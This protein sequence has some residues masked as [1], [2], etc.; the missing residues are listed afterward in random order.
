MQSTRILGL[1]GAAVVILAVINQLHRTYN[2]WSTNESV[3]I[4][5]VYQI[6]GLIGCVGVTAIIRFG[7]IVVHPQRYLWTVMSWWLLAVAVGFYV[8]ENHFYFQSSQTCSED[9]VCFGIYD[10]RGPDGLVSVGMYYLFFSLVRFVFTLA[11]ISK[12]PR[13]K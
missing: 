13:L 5:F 4:E 9:G 7:V 11:Y 8:R 1:T 2:A 12:R 10:M 6:F 3:E